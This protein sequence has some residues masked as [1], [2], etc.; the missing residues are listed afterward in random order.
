MRER[1]T[2]RRP[3][4]VEPCDAQ[5]LERTRGYADLEPELAWEKWQLVREAA[6]SD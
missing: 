1:H 2:P 3:S 4:P 6:D 5:K